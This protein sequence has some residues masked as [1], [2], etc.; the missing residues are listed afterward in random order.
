MNSSMEGQIVNHS[1]VYIIL[2]MLHV[3]AFVE[4]HHQA[5]QKH[6]ERQFKY[7]FEGYSCK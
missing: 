3:S 1:C 7:P 5:I 2:F 6:R 4:S